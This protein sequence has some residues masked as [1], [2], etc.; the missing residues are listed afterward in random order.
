MNYYQPEVNH[1]KSPKTVYVCSECDHQ[2][3]KWLGKCP[4]C[5]AWNSFVEETYRAPAA[6]SSRVSSSP[7]SPR[8]ER[9]HA[10]KFGDF[11]LPEYL[12]HSTGISEFDRVLGGGLV[13]G[14]VILLAGEPGI[15]KSTLLM[16]LCG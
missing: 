8:I 11:T 5:G 10:V 13:E 14:S 3:A 4:Q 15:G 2:S 7:S 12:R 16:Q 1:M 9:D 6:S